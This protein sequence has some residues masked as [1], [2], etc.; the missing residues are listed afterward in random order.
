MARLLLPK[1]DYL[2]TVPILRALPLIRLP[3]CFASHR[4]IA[5]WNARSPAQK[6]AGAH[7][8]RAKRLNNG[9]PNG[10]WSARQWLELL[11][12][13]GFCCHYCGRQLPPDELVPDHVTPLTR[14][15]KNAIANIVPACPRCNCQKGSK[16]EAEYLDW[17]AEHLD[18]DQEAA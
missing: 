2:M 6:L 5:R 3:A 14:G 16:T 4:D 12:A 11:E 1:D 13:H 7:Y 10:Y 8:S 18:S 17:L 15:G 9:R